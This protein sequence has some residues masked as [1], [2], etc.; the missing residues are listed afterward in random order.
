M[1]SNAF[2]PTT[3]GPQNPFALGPGETEC[4]LLPRLYAAL[5]GGASGGS[6]TET[7]MKDD[8]IKFAPPNIGQL[9]MEIRRLEVICGAPHTRARRAGPIANPWGRSIDRACYP[10]YPC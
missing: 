7:R 6:V 4:D 3:P 8:W 9:R 1:T 2:P 10:L 5:Y